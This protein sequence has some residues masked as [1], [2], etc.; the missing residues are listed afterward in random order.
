MSNARRSHNPRYLGLS[1][2]GVDPP[3]S[4]DRRPPAGRVR[5][6]TLTGLL[7]M[8]LVWGGALTAS[9]QH[10]YHPWYFLWHYPWHYHAHWHDHHAVD[11]LSAQMHAR[12][13]LELAF[14]EAAVNYAIAREIRAHAV[15]QEISNVKKFY[16]TKWILATE[17][18]QALAAKKYNKNVEKWQRIEDYKFD[19]HRQL[20][21]TMYYSERERGE[22]LSGVALNRL[23][24]RL[25]DMSLTTRLDRSQD[26]TV[27]AEL[28]SLLTLKQ[29]VLRFPA[30]SVIERREPHWIPPLDEPEFASMRQA[31][32]EA[33]AR[34]CEE[35]EQNGRVSPQTV[36]NARAPV[37]EML[38]ELKHADWVAEWINQDRSTR[39]GQRERARQ[40]LLLLERQLDEIRER[41]TGNV[42]PLELAYDVDT[43]GDHV[44]D[45]IDYMNRNGLQFAEYRPGDERAYFTMYKMLRR[46]Y[47]PL[48]DRDPITKHRKLH[49]EMVS[50]RP[51]DQ[52]P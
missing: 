17:R 36:E 23:L 30:G 6:S 21:S 38:E 45:F 40:M 15:D 1:P 7:V 46:L 22:I 34:L 31:Y 27:T 20:E 12:A 2:Q 24:N 8:G 32:V 26:L 5:S 19:V 10:P 16:R 47:Q 3:R 4:L 52:R 48:K 37:L 29:G 14:S 42:L 43:M 49:E 13:H 28:L 41:H 50:F 11:A 25:R 44:I 18:Q 33:Q 35:S 9:A 51:S 39:H